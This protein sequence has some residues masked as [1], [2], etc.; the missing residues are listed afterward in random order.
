MK[1]RINDVNPRKSETITHA[2]VEPPCTIKL[3]RAI[4]TKN[5]L[6]QL[7]EFGSLD[8][9]TFERRASSIVVDFAGS[10]REIFHSNIVEI[11]PR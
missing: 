1:Q 6:G 4:I 10:R 7:Q 11:V 8:V 2:V 3:V 9:D 5:Y